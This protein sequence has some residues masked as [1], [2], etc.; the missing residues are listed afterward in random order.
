MA[1]NPKEYDDNTLVEAIK[2]LRHS[3]SDYLGSW[4][5]KRLAVLEQEANR[6]K[7]NIQ[8][9]PKNDRHPM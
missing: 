9:T 3:R 7:L 5:K 6:R 2:R 1:F 4:G 8:P